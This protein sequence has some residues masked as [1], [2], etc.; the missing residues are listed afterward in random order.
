MIVYTIHTESR[1]YHT[2]TLSEVYEFL[3]AQG[4]PHRDAANAEGWC[5]LAAIGEEYEDD[6][7]YIVVEEL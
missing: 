6:Y 7:A 4:V 1:E 5:E 3:R 2:D